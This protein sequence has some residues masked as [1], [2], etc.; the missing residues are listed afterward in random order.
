MDPQIIS[1]SIIGSSTILATVLGAGTA[2]LIG[3]KISRRQKLQDDLERAV[4]D[5]HFCWQWKRRIARETRLAGT[6][7]SN[8]ERETLWEKVRRPTSPADSP[9][10]TGR[11]ASSDKEIGSGR[12][13]RCAIT[14]GTHDSQMEMAFLSIHSTLKL[15]F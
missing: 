9:R 6:I 8:S 2:W 7:V 11:R 1:S 5:I 14:R 12:D 4:R 10:A 15:A 3:R 13:W